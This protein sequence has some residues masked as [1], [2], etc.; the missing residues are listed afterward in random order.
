MNQVSPYIEQLFRNLSQ[1]DFGKLASQVLG[2]ARHRTPGPA[3]ARESNPVLDKESWESGDLCVALR[4]LALHAI[5]ISRPPET[6]SFECV[7]DAMRKLGAGSLDGRERGRVA[8]TRLSDGKLE[9][10]KTCIGDQNQ[11]A[12]E[13]GLPN[14]KRLNSLE[15]HPTVM[16]HTHPIQG[17]G[18]AVLNYHFS[19]Q[20]FAVFLR[21]KQLQISVVI[22]PGL[23]LAILKTSGT[24]AYSPALEERMK[25][26][27]A[28]SQM[29]F[30]VAADRRA[31][32]FTREC[33]KRLQIALYRIKDSEDPTLAKQVIL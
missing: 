21:Q 22:A 28:A 14:G 23:K 25:T 15:H 2:D 10:G 1:F 32:R 20:D 18:K 11:V 33:A 29:D 17:A 8:F 24:P 9:L 6:I 16:F 5:R 19:V 3:N 4:Q 12:I 31:I 26:W 13:F 27:L 7:G 30:S